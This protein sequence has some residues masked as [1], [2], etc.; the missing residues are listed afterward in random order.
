MIVFIDR[1]INFC[2]NKRWWFPFLLWNT[3]VSH[4]FLN[5]FIIR[6][7]V[8][9]LELSQPAVSSSILLVPSIM[10]DL[11]KIFDTCLFYIWM[12]VMIILC[13]KNYPFTHSILHFNYSYYQNRFKH[14]SCTNLRSQVY[15]TLEC[16]ISF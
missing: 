16:M 7:H 10:N 1:K 13:Y 8:G 14:F 11:N 6:L 9:G 15:Y 4:L 12:R 3:S 2:S 5:S